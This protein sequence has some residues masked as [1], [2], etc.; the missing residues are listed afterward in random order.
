MPGITESRGTRSDL[1]DEAAAW[2]AA[3]DTGMADRDAFE[4]WRGGDARRAVAFA[5]V[6]AT[7]R[8]MDVLRIA[9]ADAGAGPAI[10]P[11]SARPSRRHVMQ[12]AASIAVVTA[13]GGGVAYRA[14]A[15][16]TAATVVGQRRTVR[17]SEAMT[18]D[19]NTD[20]SIAWKAG[21]PFRLWLERGEIAIR[22]VGRTAVELL[23]EGDRLT[24]HPGV[25]N[26]RLRG[27]A[28]EVAVLAG[29]VLTATGTISAGDVALVTAGRISN[30]ALGEAD[31]A[32]I[33]AWRHDTLVLTGESLDYAV[34]E[35]NRYLVKKIVIGDPALS[36]LRL[37][38]TF[39][40]TSPAEFL[41]ALHASLGIEA[42]TG[43]GGGI[44]LT[45]A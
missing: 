17:A 36:R 1:M 20:S 32:G 37:G 22:L 40:T 15:R 21:D 8:D 26:A 34:D 23:V 28:C 13:V 35:V 44:V 19:L 4:V 42:T 6:A 27:A 16:G 30:R 38:G 11:R 39:A 33:S 31:V 29:G 7:W 25:Y 41:R 14:F 45:R 12:A 5:Q 43:R 3:L 9:S 10:E 18:V 2:L 24:L